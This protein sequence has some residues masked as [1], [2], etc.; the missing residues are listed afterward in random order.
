[1]PI[2]TSKDQHCF[3]RT[4]SEEKW[5]LVADIADY[6]S[7]GLAAYDYTQIGFVK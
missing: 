4:Q 3:P 6:G 5:G 2:R 1:M 7:P